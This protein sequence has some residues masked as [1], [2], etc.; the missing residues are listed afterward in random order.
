M[1]SQSEFPSST[2]Y[3]DRVRTVP[4]QGEPQYSYR[5]RKPF[6]LYSRNLLES[7][8]VLCLDGKN[9]LP[10]I[11]Q[12]CLDAVLHICNAHLEPNKGVN[13]T[14]GNDY[15]YGTDLH[16]HLTHLYVSVFRSELF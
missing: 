4:R 11:L 1:A 6:N 9:A 16:N 10:N 7:F 13:R 15:G 14:K 8:L 2:L 3:V 12:R 5:Y